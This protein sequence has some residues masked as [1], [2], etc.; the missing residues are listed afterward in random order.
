MIKKLEI[1]Y[2]KLLKNPAT[3]VPICLC[4]DVSGS[5]NASGKIN[6]LNKGLKEFIDAMYEDEI[7]RDSAELCIIL[8]GNQDPELVVDFESIEELKNNPRIG[9][10]TANGLTP[11][12]HAVEMGIGCLNERKELYKETDTDYYQPW[13]V[14]MSDGAP[15]DEPKVK[16]TIP[17][18]RKMIDDKKLY[19]LSVLIGK[20]ADGEELLGQY[21]SSGKVNRL[22][23][24]E[25]RK[26][27]LWLS[28]S[29]SR[30]SVSTPGTDQDPF[31][32]AYDCDIFLK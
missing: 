12:G 1:E 29:V 17:V 13:L 26:F 3:R 6:E 20:Y 11:L 28:S 5:M 25:M 8:V 24:I 18:V 10:F 4:L 19:S 31:S 7:A 15:T 16:E 30:V 32:D 27:F 9:N 22:Q 14:I 2:Q 21:A 23:E